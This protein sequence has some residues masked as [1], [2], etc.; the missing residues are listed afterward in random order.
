MRFIL[1]DSLRPGAEDSLTVATANQSDFEFVM[2]IG[3]DILLYFNMLSP[4]AETPI[5][6]GRGENWPF[7]E[8]F[9]RSLRLRSPRSSAQNRRKP[10]LLRAADST[11]ERIRRRVVVQDRELGTNPLLGRPATPMTVASPS[12][13]IW[14]SDYS[15][16]SPSR[17]RT[18]CSS[19]QTRAVTALPSSIP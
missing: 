4:G 11:G 15:A 1:L 5:A 18:S 12:T 19:A 14:P 6:P 2:R 9:R 13:T 17:A 16:A 8:R 3:I 7:G 10:V